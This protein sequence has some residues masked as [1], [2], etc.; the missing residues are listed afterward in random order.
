MSEKTIVELCKE[1]KAHKYLYCQEQYDVFFA[2][3]RDLPVKLLEIGIQSGGSLNVWR[4][5]FSRG[6]IYGID[7]DP[8]CCLSEGTFCGNQK[9]TDFLQYVINSV[10]PFNIVIDDGSHYN[11]D[12][13]VSF[14]TLFPTMEKGVYVIEDMHDDRPEF[15]CEGYIHTKD[16]MKT[17][18]YRSCIVQ[19]IGFIFKE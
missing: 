9:D 14:N 4:N 15:Y 1:F 5:Y 7:V 2:P 6:E 3:F 19:D 18:P 11:S 8:A 12:Q 16:W 17:L 13:Q 10:G